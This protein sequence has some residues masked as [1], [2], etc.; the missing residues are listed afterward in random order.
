MIALV[1]SSTVGATAAYFSDT[2]TSNDNTFTAGSLNLVL[3]EN[4][5]L[6]TVK[7][8]LSNL[9]PGSQPKGQFVLK[10]TGSVK[11]YVDLE[12]LAVT[13]HENDLIEPEEEAGDTTSSVGELQDVLHM[14][15]FWD[16]GCD[17]W[18]STGDEYIINTMSKDIASSYDQNIPVDAGS[19]VCLEGIFDW[20]NTADDN[21]AMTD[22][23][24]LDMTFELAQTSG[25]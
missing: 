23:M 7:W 17:G 14:K 11:G 24:D 6:N 22:S 8:N 2:E 5:G 21:K 12:N 4:D 13:G 16:K 1:G 9:V 18:Y 15:L 10:N 3:N 20:W 19:Q 25:Q